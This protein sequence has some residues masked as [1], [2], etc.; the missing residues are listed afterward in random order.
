M[1]F[2]VDIENLDEA[3]VLKLSEALLYVLDS[4][5]HKHTRLGKEVMVK[6][7]LSQALKLPQLIKDLGSHRTKREAAQERFAEI[8]PTLSM[9]TRKRSLEQAQFFE[10]KDLNPE[11]S[12]EQDPES[13]SQSD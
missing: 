13:T 3:T 4:R 7:S 9:N 6:G 11:E 12:S 8:W 1:P 5:L 10:P 2:T